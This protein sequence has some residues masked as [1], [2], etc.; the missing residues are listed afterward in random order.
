MRM[1][2]LYINQYQGK[3]PNNISPDIWKQLTCIPHRIISR[4][5]RDTKVT[6]LRTTYA[7]PPKHFKSSPDYIAPNTMSVK[8]CH[9]T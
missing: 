1:H 5:P 8:S 3:H 6:D 7:L 2:A 9:I 4:I